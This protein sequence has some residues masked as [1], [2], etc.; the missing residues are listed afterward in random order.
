MQCLVCKSQNPDGKK[1]CGDCGSPLEQS[2]PSLVE[3]K[4]SESLNGALDKRLEQYK[5]A[6]FELTERIATRILGWA[7]T[8]L[9]IVSI[10]IVILGAF[11]LK[12]VWDIN[13]QRED[14]EKLASTQ[15]E[16]IEK[17]GTDEV[18]Q[19]QNQLGTLRAEVGTAKEQIEPIKRQYEELGN[20]LGPLRKIRDDLNELAENQ[21]DNNN[22]LNAVE[23][24]AGFQPVPR[25]S[26]PTHL[27][28]EKIIGTDAV[29]RIQNAG[30]MT[31]QTV[32]ATGG[33]KNSSFQSAV[34]QQ[35]S[36]QF[37]PGDSHNP[38]FLYLL[39]NIVFYNGETDHYY[40]QFYEPYAN[41]AAPIL[42]IPGN[43][44]G[45]PAT[46][47]QH[48]L[49]GFLRTFC[50]A[51]PIHQPEAGPVSRMAMTQP[52][53]YWALDTPFATLIGL[54]TNV[55]RQGAIDAQQ[56]DWFQKELKAAPSDKAMIVML[57][58]PPYSMDANHSGSPRMAKILD[59]AIRSSGREPDVVFSA[60][61]FNYQR[62]TLQR[63]GRESLYIVAGVGGYYRLHQM[64]RDLTLPV[65]APD[66][67]GLTLETYYVQ[68]GFVQVT[69]SRAQ[70]QLQ[71]IAVTNTD[72]GSTA[73]VR[74]SVTFD[75]QRH[76]LVSAKAH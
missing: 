29:Q 53:V 71:F 62:F 35:L 54:Y 11:G 40:E 20:D 10:P 45:D 65:A 21:R 17:L 12:G 73:D 56:A 39:G 15:K 44:D 67:N 48:S 59:D 76:T 8:A 46:P 41:Y 33:V 19:V 6:E 9:S 26:G 75:L 58:H 28:L 74:D 51:S 25:P 1:F 63:N 64:P 38:A 37:R 66:V 24:L 2:I 55:P 16:A 49:E 18:K 68:H 43:H 72:A 30:N 69:V 60:D 52:G 50:A 32:G 47:Q 23:K 7:K 3:A 36:S 5:Q 13:H 70:L 34:A 4:I 61:V 14:I 57:N 42:A 31:F 27:A 22:R